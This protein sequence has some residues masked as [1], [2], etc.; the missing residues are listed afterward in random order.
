MA[1]NRFNGIPH[2]LLYAALVPVESDMGLPGF[3]LLMPQKEFTVGRA[4]HND[5]VI[6]GAH[7]SEEHC[8]LVWNV[9]KKNMF[10]EWLPSTNGTWIMNERYECH[11]LKKDESYPL[12]RG[13]ISFAPSVQRYNTQSG[14][15]D[16]LYSFHVY[17]EHEMEEQ[18][19]PDELAE[20]RKARARFK[21]AR[22]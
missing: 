6:R 14:P 12:I 15:N 8:K 10:V 13:E 16:H 5:I 11:R 18:L 17:S 9:E 2:P 20:R 3:D 22:L 7:I 1:F 21:T 19:E 4:E